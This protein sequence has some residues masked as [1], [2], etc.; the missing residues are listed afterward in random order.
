VTREALPEFDLYAELEVSRSASVE[1]IEAA[2]RALVKRHHPDVAP[3]LSTHPRPKARVIEAPGMQLGGGALEAS[4]GADP[5]HDIEARIKRINLARDWLTDPARR[6]RYDRAKG[7]ILTSEG[8][9]EGREAPIRSDFGPNGTDVRQYLIDLAEL[10]ERRALQVREGKAVADASGYAAAR[11]AAFTSARRRRLSEWLFSREA[12]LSVTRMRLGSTPLAL[13]IGE[14]LA[15]VAGGI[16]IRDL[17]ATADFDVLMLPWL[18]RG[19]RLT[20][21]TR[22]R[23]SREITTS[24]SPRVAARPATMPRRPRSAFE[25]PSTIAFLSGSMVALVAIGTLVGAMVFNPFGGPARTS[26]VLGAVAPTATP[27]V[28]AA[29]PLPSVTPSGQPVDPVLLASLR[30]SASHTIRTLERY[31]AGGFVR[32]AQRLLGGTAPGLQASGLR[33]ATFPDIAT[34]AIVVSPSPSGSGWVATAGTDHL[35]S[36]DGSH[37]TFDYGG[38]PLARLGRTSEHDL[39]WLSGTDRHELF[40]RITSTTITHSSVALTLSWRYG[41]DAGLGSDAPYFVGTNLV[42]AG[43]TVKGAPIQGA[44]GDVAALGTSVASARVRLPATV[45]AA[46]SVSVLVEVVNGGTTRG[47]TTIDSTFDLPS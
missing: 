16:A 18:W 31:A 15:D 9:R 8:V 47:F 27:A 5:D 29:T 40:V 37:W 11:S 6:Q 33:R 4:D 34:A 41:P 38:R 19:E 44:T 30:Q 3:R 42:I 23:P 14:A 24:T 43:I 46:A 20:E 22:T 10:D 35:T 36:A 32:G 45:D 13:E 1:T 12:A 17:V 39:Y 7:P 28:V 21:Q 26:E 2:Y 25:R